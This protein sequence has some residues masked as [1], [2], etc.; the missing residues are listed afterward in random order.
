MLK[1]TLVTLFMLTAFTAVHASAES[2]EPT[3]TWYQ[4]KAE[5]WHWYKDPPKDEPKEEEEL[6]PPPPPPPPVAEVKPEPPKPEPVKPEPPKGPEPFSTEWLNANIPKYLNKAVDDPTP[7]NVEAFYILQRLAMDKAER[8]ARV[9]E[10][11]RVG[12]RFIDETTRR[13]VSSFAQRTIDR[14][15]HDRK[16]ALIKKIGQRAGLFYF[17]RSTCGYCTKQAPILGYLQHATDMSILAIAIDGVIPEPKQFE[18]TVA[19]AGQAAMLGVESTPSIYVVDP[20]TQVYASLGEGLHELEE[21]YDRIIVVVARNKWITD[22]EVNSIRAQTHPN[23]QVDLS[24]EFPKIL[25]L[26]KQDP[27]KAADE[28]AKVM[29][30]GDAE[31]DRQKLLNLTPE[32]KRSL[33]VTDGLIDP[34]AIVAITK[35]SNPSPAENAEPVYLSFDTQAVK[36]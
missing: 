31:A 13:P 33:T 21:L 6:P 16:I 2:G 9:A 5:G 25:A 22:D 3:P 26:A 32:E 14:V 15:A 27:D 24:K 29:G 1:Q 28:L 10:Q 35:K 23:D 12:N 17:F 20:D 34:K 4:R 7:E 18:N 30:Q 36:K 19:D 8:F 11:V